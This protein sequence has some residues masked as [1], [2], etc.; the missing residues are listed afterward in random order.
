MH[1]Y[2]LDTN[3]F[4]QAHRVSYPFDIF[5]SFWEKI[6]E[7]AERGNIISIDKVKMEISISFTY[8][9]Y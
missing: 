9:M 5:N 8:Y 1:K 4:I 7:L 2:L 6:I 3:I